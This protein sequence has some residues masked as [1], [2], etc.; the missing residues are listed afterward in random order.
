MIVRTGV[1]NVVEIERDLGKGRIELTELD[2]G[3]ISGGQIGCKA[4]LRG[5]R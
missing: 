1:Y 3:Q 5:S 4:Q 2:A